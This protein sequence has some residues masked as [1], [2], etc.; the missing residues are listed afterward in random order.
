[1]KFTVQL[2][3]QPYVE[4]TKLTFSRSI[5][6]NVGQFS[7]DGTYKSDSPQ[8][9]AG[10]N[11]K[12]FFDGK[13]AFTGVIDKISIKS[14]RDGT[15]VTYSGRDLLCDAVD[16]S[17]P[18]SVKVQK[19]EI[20]LKSVCEKYLKALGLELKVADNTKEKVGN[21]PV[22]KQETNDG[23]KMLHQLSKY[24]ATYQAWLV[25]D[26]ESN[27]TI[28]R[29]GELDLDCPFY[30]LKNGNG[31]NNILDASLDVDTTQIFSKVKVR[32]KGSIAFDVSTQSTDDVVD[33]SGSFYDDDARP[34]RYLEIKLADTVSA[35]TAKKRAIDEV[36]MR[37]AKA[38]DY[39]IETNFFNTR[40][41][42]MVKIGGVCMVED[43][44]RNVSG[45]MIIR[46]FDVTFDR[47]GG[48]STSLSFAPP[49]AYSIVDIEDI[50]PQKTKKKRHLKVH[51]KRYQEKE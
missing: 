36:N 38:F 2:N 9:L 1:M 4:F 26:E 5:D 16:S 45:R 50:P 3:D 25:A 20:S 31:K 11:I 51:N 44:I 30:Y 23:Q 32:G 10:D 14:S 48:T 49:E 47:E 28:M 43:E 19:G 13:I 15:K 46:A 35:Q 33:I 8:A 39:R 40:D 24:A 12:I 6:V 42:G 17:V 41:G 37:K 21:K 7:L 34:T 29:A 18:D 27:L 22:R